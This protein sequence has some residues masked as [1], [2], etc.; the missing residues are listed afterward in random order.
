VKAGRFRE[1]LYCRLSL[2]PIELP[3]LRGRKEDIALL[4]AQFLRLASQRLNRPAPR[5]TAIDC[6]LSSSTTGR[7]TYANPRTSSSARSF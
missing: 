7:V 1:N 6:E 3:P 2:F 5:L 4:A